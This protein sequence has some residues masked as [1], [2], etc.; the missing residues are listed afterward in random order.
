MRG[1]VALFAAAVAVLVLAPV[2]GGYA[3]PLRLPATDRQ[4]GDPVA[5]VWGAKGA[6]LAG[7][8]PRTLRVHV[9]TT[10]P[11]G[12]I[13][14]WAFDRSG[15]DLLAI[16][17]SPTNGSPLDPSFAVRFVDRGSLKTIPPS[18]RLP[19]FARALLWTRPDRLTALVVTPDDGLWHAMTV[20][21]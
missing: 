15:G 18:V 5:L 21:L 13:A 1:H 8:D 6:W 19:G 2:G 16:A 3:R 9:P 12:S 17:C 7:L 4:G 10:P 11:L 20:D 14:S